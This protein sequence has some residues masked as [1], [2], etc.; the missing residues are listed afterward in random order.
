MKAAE[1]QTLVGNAPSR[2]IRL[3]VR[4]CPNDSCHGPLFTVVDIS[5]QPARLVESF[6]PQTID[7]DATNLPT[8][9]L[10][11]LEEGIRAHAA[12]CFRSAALMVRRTL[13]ELCAEQKATGKDLKARLENL[14]QTALPAALIDG[15]D[16]LRLLG[17]DAAHID[18]KDFDSVGARESE[19]AIDIAKEVLKTVY[20]HQDLV[21]RLE[22]LK[23]QP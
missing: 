20:Q 1:R 12:Q 18:L 16:H 17:N 3:G 10:T 4:R 23:R 7:F 22:A 13:E 14:T 8:G 2:K 9:V 5:V 21:G 11:A 15:L 6:P 19:L